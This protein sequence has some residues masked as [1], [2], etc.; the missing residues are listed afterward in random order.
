MAATYASRVQLLDLACT[1][2]GVGVG[3]DPRQG[4]AVSGAGR[5]N[6]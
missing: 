3:R 2:D 4:P 1:G 5:A 6:R